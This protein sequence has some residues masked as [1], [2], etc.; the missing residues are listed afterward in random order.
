M[1][2]IKLN[3]LSCTLEELV[4]LIPF[5]NEK[6]LNALVIYNS[7]VSN[8]KWGMIETTSTTGKRSRSY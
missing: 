4:A 1:N 6:K 8:I 2:I 3:I 7:D 5:I